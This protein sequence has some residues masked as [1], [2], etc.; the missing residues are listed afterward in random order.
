M[1]EN[2]TMP[3]T[4]ET[5]LAEMNGEHVLVVTLN[6]PQVRN[7]ANTRMWE[8]LLDLWTR[9]EAEPG[10][11]RCVVLT[12][13]GDQA[14]CA[15]GDLKERDGMS[16][17]VWRHQHALIERQYRTMIDLPLPVLAAVNGHAF[18]GGA[19][20]TCG[21]DMRLMRADR[22][23]WCLPEV[24]LGLPLTDPMF[25]VV[26]ARLPHATL[27]ESIV[28]GHR[29]PARRCDRGGDRHGRQGP[30]GH[31]PTQAADVRRGRRPVRRLTPSAV[32]ADNRPTP[33][34]RWANR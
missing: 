34:R 4:Y 15:G 14:F 21:F 11:V 33:A 6:R 20:L 25:A 10:A 1:S 28:T 29:R 24:D 2:K 27:H 12:G 31:R 13:A 19:M 3:F 5:L 16:T 22:G 18:A 32:D 26:S 30:T 17:A 7:A 8:E 9:L 23:Y